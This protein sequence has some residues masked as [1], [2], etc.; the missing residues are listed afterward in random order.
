VSKFLSGIDPPK[1]KTSYQFIKSI[2][3]SHGDSSMEHVRD[4][5]QNLGQ[6]QFFSFL[7]IIFLKSDTPL[8]EAPTTKMS[9]HLYGI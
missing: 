1:E 9:F 4:I 7:I 5:L 3:K 8:E 2:R 6:A